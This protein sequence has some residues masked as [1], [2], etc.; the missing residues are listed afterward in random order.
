MY[1]LSLNSNCYVYYLNEITMGYDWFML[2]HLLLWI[3]IGKLSFNLL[4]SVILDVS[5]VK[6]K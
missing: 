5:P 2:Y 4:L 1:F 6:D 3:S